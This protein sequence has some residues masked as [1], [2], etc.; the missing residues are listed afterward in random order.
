MKKLLIGVVALLVLAV[1][2]STFAAQF[3]RE[4][5]YT[6]E[7]SDRINEDLY[8]AGERVTLSGTVNGDA[9]IASGI[10]IVDGAVQQD[11][12]AAG[13]NITISGTIGD[14]VRMAGG[15][16]VVS[17]TVR[18]D[19]FVAG[20]EVHITSNGSVEGDLVS[21]G[22]SVI[23]NGLV[24][25][26]VRVSGGEVV[27]N[28]QIDGNV[29]AASGDVT[30]GSSAFIRGDFDY[31]SR[32][33]ATIM[34]GARVGG[35]TLFHK[36]GIQRGSGKILAG[37][38]GFWFFLKFLMM[39]VISVLAVYVFR[40]LTSKVLDRAIAAPGRDFLT[41]FI[42]LFLVP[43]T[44][45]LLCI[46]LVGIPVAILGVLMYVV[47][48]LL[49]GFLTPVIIGSYINKLITKR[50][51]LEM[52]WK[53]IVYGILATFILGIIPFVGGL[54]WFII[55]LIVFGALARTWYERVW[56]NL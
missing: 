29:R 40:R 37:L 32:N 50:P 14:D 55:Y 20:G 53:T 10:V 6:L 15:S 52:N 43:I 30:L 12:F 7:K 49:T 54:I 23:I 3:Q 16:I 27:L 31:Y 45:I 2:G 24:K 33:E 38:L 28:N 19:L 26:N 4:E 25:G 44:A 1:P 17:G 5:V 21:A 35:T 51:A 22:G 48:L 42:L 13:G 47:Y 34:D 41:G 46:T 18:G 11:L 56:K 39:I 8:A 36:S 9:F